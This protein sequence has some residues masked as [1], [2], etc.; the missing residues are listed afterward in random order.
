[1]IYPHLETAPAVALA[2]RQMQTGGGIV[3]VILDGG[4][5]ARAISRTLCHLFTLAE[6]LG[7]VESLVEHPAL[8]THAS[9]PPSDAKNSAST[10]AWCDCRLASK[11]CAI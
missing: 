5:R 8:M 6:S 4:I 2:K 3:T 9:I 11:M 7:G 10:M 1:M